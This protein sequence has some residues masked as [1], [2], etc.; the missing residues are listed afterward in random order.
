MKKNKLIIIFGLVLLVLGSLLFMFN[1]RSNT[2]TGN[3]NGSRVLSNEEA[4][5]LIKETVKKV[6]NIYENPKAVFQVK[7]D[8]DKEEYLKILTYD[9]DIKSLFTENGIKELENTKFNNKA[10][11]L[12]EENDVYF[13]ENIPSDNS[14]IK[15]TVTVGNKDIKE[16]SINCEVTFTTYRL[17]DDDSLTYYVIVKELKLVKVEK[18][19]DEALWLVE[20]FKYNNE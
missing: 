7:E 8:D 17:Q 1:K 20:S 3:G 13:L 18:E 14:F 6:V 19:N 11:F 10:F 9:V 12:R 2:E 15:S 5:S 16:K 4:E